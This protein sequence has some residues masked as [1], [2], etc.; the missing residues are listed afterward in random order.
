[1][2]GKNND[3]HEAVQVKTCTYIVKQIPISLIKSSIEHGTTVRIKKYKRKTLNECLPKY[4]MKQNVF[5]VD[6]T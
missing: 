4:T 3:K 5:T 2:N 6:W 1:M